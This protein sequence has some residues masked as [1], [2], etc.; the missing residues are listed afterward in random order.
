MGSYKIRHSDRSGYFVIDPNSNLRQLRQFVSQ[1]FFDGARPVCIIAKGKGPVKNDQ[2]LQE[3][4]RSGEVEFI[5]V[6]RS[7]QNKPNSVSCEP[8]PVE[9]TP[10]V[11]QEDA[12]E[13]KFVLGPN[14]MA[15][16]SQLGISVEQDPAQVR[17]QLE[18]M[19]APL[20]NLMRQYA[21][22]GSESPKIVH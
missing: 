21:R 13:G 8:C 15:I 12:K 10:E 9:K 11:S 14:L 17:K 4:L 3:V 2:L 19:P 1:E 20:P 18:Q 22:Q 6:H 5:F 7:P 16:F